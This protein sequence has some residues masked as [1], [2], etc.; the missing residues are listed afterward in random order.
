VCNQLIFHTG[1]SLPL[2]SCANLRW[3]FRPNPTH[4]SQFL[5]VN[6]LN[7][8]CHS[9][10]SS[11]TR[12]MYFEKARVAKSTFTSPL[13]SKSLTHTITFPS[14]N[15]TLQYCNLQEWSAR[16]LYNLLGLNSTLLVHGILRLSAVSF[17]PFLSSIVRL[18]QDLH[19]QILPSLSLRNRQSEY[20]GIFPQL[21]NNLRN[22]MSHSR[23]INPNFLQASN[24]E[25]KLYIHNFHPTTNGSGHLLI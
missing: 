21:H 15:S 23:T 11:P 19:G 20:F 6:P 24:L 14:S 9:Q 18:R 8:P 2:I 12:C 1:L 10:L 25:T 13:P 3:V 4:I 17:D 5:C 7:H 16:R 22:R